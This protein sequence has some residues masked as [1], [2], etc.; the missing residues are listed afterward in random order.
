[1]GGGAGYTRDWGSRA[2]TVEEVALEPSEPHRSTRN[3]W[4]VRPPWLR[5]VVSDL[6]LPTMAVRSLH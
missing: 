3:E 4:V 1:M 6:Q 5:S 2:D